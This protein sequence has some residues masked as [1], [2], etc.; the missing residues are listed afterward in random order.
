MRKIL[1]ALGLAAAFTAG[2][3]LSLELKENSNYEVVGLERSEKPKV[4]EFFS[5]GCPHCFEFE[6]HVKAWLA[7]KPADI[8]VLR[9]PVSFGREEWGFYA[10]AY[11]LAEALKLQEQS[12][13]RLFD[14]IHKDGKPMHN[15]DDLVAFF[16]ELGQ[17]EAKVRGTLKS[18]PVQ[19]K[20][21]QADFLI[22]KF[23][24]DSVPTFIA[25]DQY[26]LIMKSRDHADGLDQTTLAE[27]LT[28][29]AHKQ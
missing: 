27:G 18:F 22:K 17:D 13:E 23:R 15:E 7:T 9:V 19:S 24:I 8:Q 5:Y 14:R 6:P 3:A 2:P 20:L 25:N 1:I 29:L 12:H 11:Y 28:A 21:K 4:L 10:Q 16:V 26:K